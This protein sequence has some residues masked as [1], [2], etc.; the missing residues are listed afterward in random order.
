MHVHRKK[1]RFTRL[2]DDI[3]GLTCD[4]VVRVEQPTSVQIA[5][6]VPLVR[7]T[8][9][10]TIPAAAR[11]TQG[12]TDGPTRA[13]APSVHGLWIDGMPVEPGWIRFSARGTPG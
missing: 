1:R 13:P 6:P 11:S 9:H 8:L 12:S 2:R 4:R 5:V 7:V 3:N 10:A